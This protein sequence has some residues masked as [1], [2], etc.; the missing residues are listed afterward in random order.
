M[1][2]FHYFYFFVVMFL[3]KKLLINAVS[4]GSN[5][6]VLSARVSV[7]VSHSHSPGWLVARSLQHHY[8]PKR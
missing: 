2:L 4:T 1:L 5:P 3:L 7:S 8:P 6:S